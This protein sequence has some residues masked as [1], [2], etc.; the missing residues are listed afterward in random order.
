MIVYG[1]GPILAP[2]GFPMSSLVQGYNMISGS[3]VLCKI[4]PHMR[5]GHKPMKEQYRLKFIVPPIKI[6]EPD[7]VDIQIFFGW[8]GSVIHFK[9]RK[10]P[11]KLPLRLMFGRKF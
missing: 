1:I 2:L 11:A 9:T 8:L 10:D 5:M 6:M 7:S 4:I 3:K